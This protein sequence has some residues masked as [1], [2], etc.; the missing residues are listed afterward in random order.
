VSPLVDVVVTHLAMHSAGELRASAQV[1]EGV[2][3]SRTP[4][5]QAGATARACYALVGAPWHWT[6]R[7]HLDDADWQ[8][9]VEAEQGEV[10]VASDAEGTVGYFH[11]ARHADVVELR[12][13]GLTPRCIGRG[14]GGWLLTRAAE[15]AWS[16]GPRRVILNTCTLDGEAALPNYLKRGFSIVREERRLRDIL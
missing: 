6:D 11:L 16:L 10:W 13:F 4:D 5:P 3:V 1:P 12:Y 8:A 7:A 14:I 2:R 9:L 15:R